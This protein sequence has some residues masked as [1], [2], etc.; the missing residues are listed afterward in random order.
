MYF[1]YMIF[2]NYMSARIQTFSISYKHWKCCESLDSKSMSL[3]C[4]FFSEELNSLLHLQN[5]SFCKAFRYLNLNK[6]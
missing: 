1:K 4:F 6:Q 3:C 5:M 2:C